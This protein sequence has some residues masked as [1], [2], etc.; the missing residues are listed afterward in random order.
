MCSVIHS[1]YW[2]LKQL[3]YEYYCVCAA[4]A[5][6]SPNMVFC[7]FFEMY[8]PCKSLHCKRCCLFNTHKEILNPV[9]HIVVYPYRIDVVIV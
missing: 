4:T 7:F 3:M 5:I 8:N 6:M 2:I 9:R 1:Y